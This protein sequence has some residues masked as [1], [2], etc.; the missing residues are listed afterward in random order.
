MIKKALLLLLLAAVWAFGSWWYYTCMIK[1]F[2]RT[3]GTFTSAA[4]RAKGAAITTAAATGIVVAAGAN[5]PK[6][7]DQQV[8]ATD[9]IDQDNDAISDEDERSLGTD[10]SNDDSDSDGIK[11]NEELGTD[12]QN[13]T[14]TDGDGIINALDDDDDNDTLLSVDELKNG[15][16]PLS[17]DSDADGLDDPTEVSGKLG[18]DPMNPDSDADGISDGIEI[19]SNISQPIDTDNDGTI[20]AL[21][22]DDDDDGLPTLLESKLSSDPLSVDSD[23]DGISDKEEVGKDLDQPMDTDGD[24]ILD[25]VDDSN[26]TPSTTDITD[27]ATPATPEQGDAKDEVTI[28]TV[29]SADDSPADMDIPIQK[30]RL[31][32]PFRSANPRLSG[33]AKEYFEEVSLWLN[34]S[35]SNSIVLTGHTDSIGKAKSNL[36]LGL[37]RAI[38]IKDLMV[39]LGAKSA[40]IDVASMGE[41]QPIASNKTEAGRHQNRRVELIPTVKK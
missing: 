17:V 33:A 37:K 21:D 15:T 25:L 20:D 41:T 26:D 11:D 30:S 39:K 13:P 9:F 32:F 3:N 28:D 29:E 35:P 16:D 34:Q 19:G 24:G 18:T 8:A 38:E 14:D 7:D 23:G 1:G 22:S 2:C 10:P 40:Q 36:N 5:T 6:E 27:T 12:L 31:Y 4:E